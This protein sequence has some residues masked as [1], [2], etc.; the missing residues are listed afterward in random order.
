MLLQTCR[1][2]ARV[3]S[4][5]AKNRVAVITGERLKSLTGHAPVT[6]S[7]CEPT[8][9][10]HRP[11][12]TLGQSRLQKRLCQL[13]AVLWCNL[14][15]AIY[16]VYQVETS[17]DYR[18]VVWLR[19]SSEF[20]IMHAATAREDHAWTPRDGAHAALQLYVQ[21]RIYLI[22]CREWIRWQHN[23]SEH[24][25]IKSMTSDRKFDVVG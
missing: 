22:N 14:F 18:Q 13:C 21:S 9:H 8:I 10:N 4:A 25:S 11:T 12:M 7:P 16:R 24:L 20:V 15:S 23:G 17:Q 2:M 19:L 1:R 6:A 5:A 3:Q